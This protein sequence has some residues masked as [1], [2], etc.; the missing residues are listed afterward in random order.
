MQSTASIQ[1]NLARLNP[2]QRD[3]AKRAVGG[4]AIQALRVTETGRGAVR[5]VVTIDGIMT[6]LNLG[7]RGKVVDRVILGPDFEA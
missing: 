2:M 6:R 1:A 4:T 7:P 5:V 3:A